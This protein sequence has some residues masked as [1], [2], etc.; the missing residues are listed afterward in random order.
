[1]KNVDL[2]DADF[3]HRLNALISKE[4]PYAF[5]SRCGISRGSMKTFVDK[6]TPL[7]GKNLIRLKRTTGVSLDWLLAGEG[8]MFS[9]HALKPVLGVKEAAQEPYM[10]HRNPASSLW[11][12]P[13]W[14]AYKRL[15]MP[16]HVRKGQTGLFAC[17][18]LAT[19]FPE[20]NLANDELEHIL[21]I[22]NKMTDDLP[23]EM[24]V[25]PA[26]VRN[27]LWQLEEQGT[28]MA[29]AGSVGGE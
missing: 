3:A 25:T 18:V 5:A 2:D 23:E 1:M 22:L 24:P 15:V 10:A 17:Q 4:N 13:V 8:T 7:T 28:K 29:I 14:A 26:M 21:A 9:R 27:W 16:D 6:G 12:A 11:V 19:D 20:L